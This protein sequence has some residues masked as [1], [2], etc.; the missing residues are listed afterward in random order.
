M[1][2]LFMRGSV[3]AVVSGDDA[4]SQYHLRRSERIPDRA[5]F[6]FL[7]LYRPAVILGNSNTPTALGFVMPLFHWAM[8][9]RYHSIHKNDLARARVAR[10]E[11]VVPRARAGQRPCGSG[12]EDSRVQ[13][14]GAVLRGGR[15][16]RAVSRRS[17]SR[18]T[19]L[20]IG[21]RVF[22]LFRRLWRES[23]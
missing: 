10:S 23:A 4:A 20:R 19:I 9:S 12:G 7:G 11:Q 15:Q 22:A 13:G 3:R 1:A 16:R 5:E 8:P 14:D 6:D 17:I 18:F 2:G 21:V